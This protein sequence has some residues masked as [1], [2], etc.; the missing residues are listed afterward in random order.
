MG[1]LYMEICSRVGLPVAGMP[2]DDG[3]AQ[4]FLLWPTKIPLK[5]GRSEY[6]I[7][8]YSNGDLLEKTEACELLGLYNGATNSALQPASKCQI[9]SAL[10]SYMR[11]SYWARAVGCSPEP[12]FIEPLDSRTVS[13]LCWDMDWEEGTFNLRRAIACA[14]R[15]DSP[16]AAG[17]YE[18]AWQELGVYLERGGGAEADGDA[19]VRLLMERIR[20]YLEFGVTQRSEEAGRFDAG[21]GDAAAPLKLSA[22]AVA[23]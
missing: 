18:A 5:V 22:V 16:Y 17:D 6:L 1:I 20:M 7:D 8:P 10:L 19:S 13:E 11:E 2:V 3:H 14:E 21:G 9:L 15:Q 12:A 4:Y 23:D